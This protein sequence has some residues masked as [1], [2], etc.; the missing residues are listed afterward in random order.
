M[1]AGVLLGSIA[2]ISINSWPLVWLGFEL[3][4]I[5]FVPT[6]IKE[7]NKKKPAIIYFIVQ[8]VGSIIILSRSIV[9]ESKVT[10]CLFILI[11]LLIK[12]GAA[13]FHFWLP[14]VLRQLNTTGLFIIITWQK[15]APL[16]LTTM[17]IITKAFIRFLNLLIGSFIITVITRQIIVI[18]FSGIR[19][20][21]WII[22]IQT[23]ILTTFI[24][25][26][27]IILFPIIF[28]LNTNTKNFFWG[29][30][31]VGGLPPF[32]GFLIKIKAL[33]RIK[34]ATAFIFVSARAVALSCYS[35]IIINSNYRKENLS[36]LTYTSL[37]VGIV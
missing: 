3:N 20:M 8:R 16:W 6:F 31:N 30:I 7:E 24:F 25:I 33:A 5:N 17:L 9:T 23:K 21:G 32:S 27:Y 26:Y 37:I 15:L 22:I 12:L 19:Q 11:G 4:L 29:M 13:P 34:K 1:A 36:I 10:M 35:R 14:R 18:I 28:Y 2:A